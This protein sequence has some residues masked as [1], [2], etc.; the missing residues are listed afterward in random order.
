MHLKASTRLPLAWNGE[1]TRCQT[2]T[3]VLLSI[4]GFCVNCNWNGSVSKPACI[5]CG[6]GKWLYDLQN[7]KTKN[8]QCWESHATFT[9]L[10]LFQL[11]SPVSFSLLLLSCSNRSIGRVYYHSFISPDFNCPCQTSHS[12]P[13]HLHPPIKFSLVNGMYPSYTLPPSKSSCSTL[14]LPFPP[15]PAFIAARFL[16]SARSLWYS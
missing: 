7:K 9:S 3:S 12:A 1:K 6:N 16:A 5:R 10:V 2:R 15:L 8:Q 14:R 4:T 11:H 13:P